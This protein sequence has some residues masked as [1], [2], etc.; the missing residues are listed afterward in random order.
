M[1]LIF[2]PSPQSTEVTQRGVTVKG[3]IRDCKIQVNQVVSKGTSIINQSGVCPSGLVNTKLA[4]SQ[5]ARGTH[6]YVAQDAIE[7]T[8]AK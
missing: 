8:A 5:S 4:V 6:L 3:I 1:T 2:H 7:V